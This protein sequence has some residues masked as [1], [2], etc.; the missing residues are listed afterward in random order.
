[1][2]YP[3]ECMKGTIW[4]KPTSNVDQIAEDVVKTI[5]E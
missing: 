3:D 4:V 2:G 5:K 1:M